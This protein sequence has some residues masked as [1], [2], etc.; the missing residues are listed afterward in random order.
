MDFEKL[1]Y[2]T[3]NTIIIRQSVK[4][5]FQRPQIMPLSL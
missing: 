3:E 1:T 2:N 5:V 4:A